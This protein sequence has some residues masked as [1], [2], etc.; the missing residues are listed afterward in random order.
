MSDPGKNKL[1]KEFKIYIFSRVGLAV[2]ATLVVLWGGAKLFYFF[3]GSD[4]H[5][6][7]YHQV[8]D[9][10][11]TLK[12]ADHALK[13]MLDTSH[14]E[15]TVTGEQSHDAA[16]PAA[17]DVADTHGA[18]AAA[19]GGAAAKD[20]EATLHVDTQ[21]HETASEDGHSSLEQDV[22]DLFPNA[23]RG[24]AFVTALI[25]P[26]DYELSQR[27]LGWRPNDVFTLFT[28]NVENYQLGVLEVTRRTTEKLVERIARTGSTIKF[29]KNLNLARAKF[30][31]DPKKYWLPAPEKSYAQAIEELK[32]YRE[33]LNSNKA[34]FHSRADNLIPLLSSFENLLGDCDDDLVKTHEESGAP[35]STF[36]ADDY[37]YY[38][39][40]VS[41]A[42]ATILEAVMVDFAPVLD[43]RGA[44]NDLHHA[45]LM[46]QHATELDP[47]VVQESDYSG[48]FAN[49]RANM[50]AFIS[51]ARAYIQFVI[52]TMST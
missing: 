33:R 16:E 2:I 17:H 12:S 15:A 39:Q 50:A 48:F 10:N 7:P 4:E 45:V 9:N 6:S 23:V 46:L 41:R 31:N 32:T 47:L 20:H 25:E 42:M 18:P 43:S 21:T 44:A 37:F 24:T 49:H 13:K 29:D 5:P 51:H 3:T 19:H 14:P 1:S 30:N 36:K 40:G 52:K 8:V 35:V 27:S 28:D 11:P 22:A 34:T 26:L 38:A